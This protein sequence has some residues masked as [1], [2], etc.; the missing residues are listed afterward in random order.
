MRALYFTDDE[1]DDDDDDCPP[2]LTR[3]PYHRQF[4]T[5]NLSDLA[6]G[7]YDPPIDGAVLHS[8]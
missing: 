6:G 5:S 4:W 3:H 8:K 2:L 1:Y 7:C